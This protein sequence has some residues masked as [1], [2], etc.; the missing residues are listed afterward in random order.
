MAEPPDRL[1]PD[2]FDA[3]IF[4][5]GGV[6]LLP[7]VEAGRT[8]IR[9]LG[10]DSRPE[11]WHR[12]YYAANL[13]VDAMDVVDWPS[14]RRAIAAELGIPAAQLDAAVP[15]IEELIL[16][17]PWVAAP[18]AV[19][20]LWSLSNA[21]YLLAVVSNAFGTV[22]EELQQNGVC[23]ITGETM[24]RVGI[25]IDS[26][27]VGLEK[28]DPRIF[29][30]ALDALGVEA[31]RSLYVGDTVKFDVLGAQAAGLHPVHVD[32]FGLCGG[33]HSHIATLREL[34]DWL[35]VS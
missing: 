34:T 14:I 9:T 5:A 13:V 35:V 19:D 25:V 20:V 4:D 21:G 22:A 12:A 28:P 23:S 30:L 29:N 32:P 31:S 7:D 15:L 24:P 2:E 33:A 18:Q 16:S 26:H 17:T 3:V 8:A 11:D 10:Y 1:S 27:I 6:L